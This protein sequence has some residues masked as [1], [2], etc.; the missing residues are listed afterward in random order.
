MEEKK[1]VDCPKG[2]NGNHELGRIDPK[3][4]LNDMWNYTD[5]CIHCGKVVK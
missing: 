4:D 3:G 5:H 2:P 1:K